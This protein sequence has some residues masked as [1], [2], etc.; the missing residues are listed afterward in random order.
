MRPLPRKTAL[1]LFL[2]IALPFAMW[3][4]RMTMDEAISVA[5]HQSVEALSARQSF[6]ST[7]WAWRSYKATRLPSLS[8]Y[9]NLMNYNRSLVL[10]QS[11][12]DGALKYLA[13]NNLQ[14][15]IGLSISQNVTF[16]GG[17]I[18]AFSD[19]S[20][21]D[22]FASSKSLTWY[23]QP[24]SISYRQPLFAYNQFKWDKL[25]AP[26][27]YERGKRKY[28]EAMEQITIDVVN[29]YNALI[30]ARMNNSI[31]YSNYQNTVKMHGI[32]AERMRLGSVTR[33]EYL[34]LELRMLNDSI[35][36]NETS[37]AIRDAQM[38]LNSIL[39]YDE[40]FEIDPVLPE[41]LPEVKLDYDMVV[42]KF[43]TNSQFDIDN[44]INILQAEESVAKAKADRG[45]TMT[46]NAKFGLTDTSPDFGGAYNRPLDQEVVGLS[47]SVPIFDWGL[48]RGKVQKAKAAEEV[49][50]AQ[51]EQSRNDRRR[52]IYTA[53]GQ[54]NN[55]AAQ[56]SV[57]RRA[58]EVAGERYELTMESFRA[59]KA[60]VTDLNTARSENDS[61]R[62]K[63]VNDISD[64]WNYYY[65]LR[66]Y[67]LYD[68]IA[69]DDLRLDEE[70]LL[71]SVK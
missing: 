58:M 6:I 12:E 10:L 3:G 69:G 48:G 40:S 5:R 31:A 23:S 67:A 57:S 33:D 55:Q 54:F 14:N 21:M 9:G 65:K 45:I 70:E 20:R 50:K 8:L 18:T 1:T 44:E 4:Q 68:F 61:A 24:I 11:Y 27:E 62:R 37:V 36:I 35:S 13:T 63:Y 71:G 26:K 49:V 7:Y 59:G 38:R 28:I 32:A 22:Q 46:L 43:L 41:D 19:L 42:D 2:L 16:T 15:N 17:V 47:F 51:V 66:Q 52:T 29:A 39:G 64:F 56:C 60:S 34:Q 25:I 53:V 30:L